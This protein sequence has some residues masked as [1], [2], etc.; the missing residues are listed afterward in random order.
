MNVSVLRDG[1]NIELEI[2]KRWF[3]CPL[4]VDQNTGKNLY[5]LND[6]D[7]LYGVKFE[8]GLYKFYEINTLA[9]YWHLQ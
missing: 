6:I 9:N 4:V 8:S 1:K 5:A 2:F 7:Y 3:D